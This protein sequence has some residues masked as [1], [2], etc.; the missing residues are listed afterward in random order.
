MPIEVHRDEFG[1]IDWSV[2]SDHAHRKQRGLF[3][4]P[5]LVASHLAARLADELDEE[6]FDRVPTLCDPFI[7]A[8]VLP[9]AVIETLAPLAA[10][11]WGAS[12]LDS[13]ARLIEATYGV[14]LEPRNLSLAR[15]V[16][17]GCGVLA[18]PPE[19]QLGAFDALT[20]PLSR[21]QKILP[22]G[23]FDLVVANPPW[24]KARVNDREFFAGIHP[25][26][27]RLHRVERDQLR[28]QLLTDAEVQEAYEAYR[29]RIETLKEVAKTDYG[30]ARAGGD[31]DMYKLAVERI[32]QLLRPGGYGAVIVPHGLLGDWGAR[33]LRK[34]LFSRCEIRSITRLETGRELFPEIHANLGVI[35]IIFRKTDNT[36]RTT[37]KISR[38]IR[39]ADQLQHPEVTGIPHQLVERA[40]P[41]C[42]I[43]LVDS[44]ADLA[45][46]ERCLDFP[47]L[48]DWPR[49]AFHP[50]REIDMTNDRRHFVPVGESVPLIEGKHLSPFS[51]AVDQRRWDVAAKA[52]H[53]ADWT[54]IAW[55]AVADRAMHRR[56]IA[57]WVP[58]GVGL[59]NSLIYSGALHADPEPL[60]WLLAWMN[61]RVA[62]AQLRLWC[63]NNNINIF[64][65]KVCR[66]PRYDRDNRD[67]RNLVEATNDLVSWGTRG[68]IKPLPPSRRELLS[69][70]NARALIDELDE[71]WRL[72][73]GFDDVVWEQAALN[74]TNPV[75]GWFDLPAR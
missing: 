65:L 47:R 24:E 11:L 25:G 26:F 40:T 29:T 45:F 75:S 33:H 1:P 43:P 39:T 17:S 20:T 49:S 4:T 71:T 69:D 9:A 3:F 56:L 34:E 64:H 52:A 38:A 19:K 53:S 18:A 41:H 37:L 15:H 46:L 13:R 5:W 54:R 31:L 21:W 8:G 14:D 6:I 2:T 10:A 35:V 48:D 63:S 68:A 23:E 50:R 59:G 67:H 28:D 12:V 42:M 72:I 30:A 74:R 22:R 27:S 7:G 55:R 16:L 62:E 66:A 60:L 70:D 61:S 57:A 58:E 36:R 73:Y 44:K 32:V 51:V